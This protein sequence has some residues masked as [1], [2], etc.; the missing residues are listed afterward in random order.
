MEL[1]AQMWWAGYEACSRDVITSMSRQPEPE[2]PCE[3]PP[4]VIPFPQQ[5][6]PRD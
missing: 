5:R 4:N 1:L 2:K 6:V 3:L